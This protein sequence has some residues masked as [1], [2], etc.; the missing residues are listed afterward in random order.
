MGWHP[1]E[2][3]MGLQS[4]RGR[5][6]AP[7]GWAWAAPAMGQRGGWAS[8]MHSLGVA[9]AL[10]RGLQPPSRG[11]RGA[12]LPGQGPMPFSGLDPGHRCPLTRECSPALSSR[13][14]GPSGC[15]S[16]C[17][18]RETEPPGLGHGLTPNP[19]GR[20]ALGTGGSPQTSVDTPSEQPA[21]AMP[22]AL[23]HPSPRWHWPT[24]HVGVRGQCGRKRRKQ[25]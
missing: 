11:G 16:S 22:A 12:P 20:P 15:G 14:G 7:E 25:H 5:L 19:R 1:R 3:W 21:L 6:A 4:L 2:P 18:P 17:G 9:G 24:V 10:P 23:C 8:T 13:Q